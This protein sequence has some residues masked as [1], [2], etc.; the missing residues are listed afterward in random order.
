M[1]RGWRPTDNFWGLSLSHGRDE[2]LM[3]LL[4]RQPRFYWA[5]PHS[6]I[7]DGIPASVTRAEVAVSVDACLVAVQTASPKLSASVFELSNPD[8]ADSWKA[9]VTFS[10]RDQYVNFLKMARSADGVALRCEYS[11]QQIKN[12]IDDAKKKLDE[13][14]AVHRVH[15]TSLTMIDLSKAKKEYRVAKRG[16]CIFSE[17]KKTPGHICCLKTLGPLRNATPL[18]SKALFDTTACEVEETSAVLAEHMPLM[19]RKKKT[20]EKLREKVQ[21]GV[22][23]NVCQLTTVEALRTLKDTNTTDQVTCPICYDSLG[24]DASLVALTRCGHMCCNECMLSWIQEKVQRGQVPSCIECRKPVLGSQLVTVDPK[25]TDDGDRF[26]RRREKA[27]SL[28]QQA[29]AT[30]DSNHGQLPPHL[31][32][33]LYLAIDPPLREIQSFHNT[34]TAIPPLVLAHIRNATAMTINCTKG[35]PRDNAVYR[36]SSKIRALLA[37]LPRN[38]VSVVFAASKTCVIHLLTVLEKNGI[39]C[40]GLYAGQTEL[41]SKHAVSDWQSLNEVLVLVVQAGVAACGLTLTKA[42][43]MF[44]M[45]PFLKHE[46]EKQAYAR[47]HR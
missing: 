44:L 41:H 38:E 42:S 43:K 28:V 27:K 45:E 40:R 14:M 18:T 9:L 3:S 2:A 6:V 47:L 7:L 21:T 33:A 12:R 35:E 32:E 17:E 22:A 37:D 8:T 11:S 4:Q 1:F 16:L 15:P 20:V 46:E 31:W 10:S 30:L 5:H 19:L 39:G 34:L 25:K 26:E 29:A 36:L 24:H 13:C 23:G